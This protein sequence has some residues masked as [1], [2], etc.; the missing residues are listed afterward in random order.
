L[1]REQTSRRWVTIEREALEALEW[2]RERQARDRQRAGGTW[3]EQGVIF[4][5]R[6]GR[7]PYWPSIARLQAKILADLGIGPFTPYMFF[8]H[9]HVTLLLAAGVPPQDVAWRTGHSLQTMIKVYA[10]R[11]MERDADAARRFADVLAVKRD[12]TP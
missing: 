10:H 6:L 1:K 4:T 11:V 3:T 12:G 5:T 7:T 8:R 2:Q 9:A